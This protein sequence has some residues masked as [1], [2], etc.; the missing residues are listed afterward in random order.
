MRLLKIAF[1]N[2]FFYSF[3]IIFSL[4][5]YVHLGILICLSVII[6]PKRKILKFIRLA[7]R[8]YGAVIIRILPWPFVRLNYKNFQTGNLKPPYIFVCNHRAASDPF[9]MAVFPYEIVQIVNIWPFRLPALGIIAK[10][11]GYL[12]I[13]EMPYAEF[14]AKTAQYIKEGVSIAAFP[15]GTRSRNKSVGQFHSAIFRTALETH[16]TIIPVC[17]TGNESVPP[18]G[19]SLLHPGVIKIH[20]L[21]ALTWDDYKT[22]S[23]FKL[24]NHVRNIIAQEVLI[25][26]KTK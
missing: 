25:M 10:I 8:W 23:P 19:S 18:I 2:F 5:A 3:F 14:T 15:E 16:A 12:N 22:F 4:T 20:R 26:D 9:L 13:R 1:L 11:A 21:A 6:L 7:I 24:K 17:I